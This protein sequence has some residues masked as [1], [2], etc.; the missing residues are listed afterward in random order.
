MRPA[1]GLDRTQSSETHG[2]KGPHQSADW[3]VITVDL[4]N[5]SLDVTLFH[6][7]LDSEYFV[8]EDTT[9]TPLEI[10]VAH[11]T[12]KGSMT[13]LILLAHCPHPPFHLVKRQ[14]LAQAIPVPK[15][16]TAD[17]KSPEVDWAEV[18]GENKPSLACNLTHG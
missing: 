14:I 16:T 15:E 11:M 4:P 1:R 12:I 3:T 5:T 17:G 10:E 9:H 8:T 7:E 2:S 6:M 13:C 18:V